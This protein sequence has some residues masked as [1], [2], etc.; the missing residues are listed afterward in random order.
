MKASLFLAAIPLALAAPQPQD[1]GVIGPSAFESL[2]FNGA[3]AT[4]LASALAG[5]PASAAFADVQ[6]AGGLAFPTDASGSV[7]PGSILAAYQAAAT[8]LPSSEQAIYTSI[9]GVAGGLNSGAGAVATSAASSAAAAGSSAASA[10]SSMI[11]SAASA[12]SASGSHAA[13]AASASGSAA[14]SAASA[15]AASKSSSAG[16]SH[17]TM[18]VGM[19]AGMLAGVAGVAVAL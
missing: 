14:A 10:A 6:T 3:V 11:T 19:M 17:Q 1:D 18:A 2:G 8:I 5:G 16:A 15:S 12:A 9:L 13:S 4:Y 7:V